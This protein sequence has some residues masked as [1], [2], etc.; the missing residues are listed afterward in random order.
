MS[1]PQFNQTLRSRPLEIITSTANL[2]SAPGIKSSVLKV[3]KNTDTSVGTLTGYYTIDGKYKWYQIYLKDKINNVFYA[4]VRSDLVN[5]NAV[6]VIVNNSNTNTEQTERQK[7]L[8]T[9][10]DN[11]IL[12]YKRYLVY[13]EILKRAEQN[14]ITLPVIK[15]PLVNIPITGQ[16]AFS[17]LMERYTKR[18]NEIKSQL[19]FDKLNNAVKENVVDSSFKQLAS[20]YS[21]S[22]NLRGLGVAWYI[23]VAI[24]VA[25]GI[26]A[27]YTLYLLLGKKYTEQ[28]IDL[29]IS[30]DLN[31]ALAT[32]PPEKK[33]AVIKDLQDQINNAYGTGNSDGSFS[34][35]LSWI[36]NIAIFTA[37]AAVLY[38]GINSLSK[39]SKPHQN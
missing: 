16:K 6:S 4:Y 3:I 20:M 18:Q 34:G 30:D 15:L 29:K 1:S 10:I 5:I 21:F 22:H 8:K 35:T 28:K 12:L 23:P 14:K 32:L 17:L 37:G 33:A 9:V 13:A 11:D 26:V 19:A 2:R 31:K 38:Y 39:T 27:S 25:V 7:L 36:K 24:I